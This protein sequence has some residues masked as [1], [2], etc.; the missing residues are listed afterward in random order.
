M[1]VCISDSIWLPSTL[2]LRVLSD[3]MYKAVKVMFVLFSFIS[4]GYSQHGLNLSI[5]T[6]YLKTSKPLLATAEKQWKTDNQVINQYTDLPSLLSN[7]ANTYQKSYGNGS[8]ST[9]SIR[10]GSTSHSLLMWN[11]VPLLSPMLGLQNLSLIP[12]EISDKVSLSKD[13]GSTLWGSG[14]ISGAINLSSQPQFKP[15]QKISLGVN[16]GSFGLYKNSI[17]TTLSSSK[18]EFRLRWIDRGADGDFEYVVGNDIKQLDNAAYAQENLISELF[19]KPTDTDVLSF[20]FWRQ[21]AMTEIPPTTTQNFSDA[22]Q[23]DASQKYLL[24]W[25]KVK[26]RFSLNSKV[27]YIADSQVYKDPIQSISSL[28]EFQTLFAESNLKYE[29]TSLSIFNL[30]ISAINN[31]AQSKN[32]IVEQEEIRLAVYPSYNWVRGAFS[33]HIATR[34]EWQ[35]KN[36]NPIMPSY[37]LSYSSDAILIETNVS[38]NYRNPSLNDLYWNPGGN[39][40][41]LPESGWS[42]GLA[43]KY[44]AAKSDKLDYT[45]SVDLYNRTIANWI[46]WSLRDGTSFFSPS[47][48]AKVWSRGLETEI[49]LYYTNND[50]AFRGAINYSLTKSTNQVKISSPDIAVGEQLLYTPMHMWSIS[51]KLIYKDISINLNNQYVGKT[52]GINENI[53][54]YLITN[55]F[56]GFKI[57]SEKKQTDT[58][59]FLR[60]NNLWNNNYR[61]IE[62]RPMPGRNIELGINYT[63]TN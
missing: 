34:L 50:W 26:D 25:L 61:V 3:I 2:V 22:S 42:Q 4:I 17:H 30:G 39:P 45:F 37:K 12:L 63:I 7:G 46:L 62:R 51:T 52:K 20:H 54:A 18:L 41:L 57:G 28:N 53:E 56:L 9:L 36:L 19:Y 48:I 23:E 58:D 21:S 60:C 5:D 14:A 15:L 38:R 24:K 6:I 40:S 8:L 47:N 11:D 27:A 35:G 55:L 13:G 1:Y 16:A 31:T 49:D 59:L 44:M 43:L 10:G 29:A 32:Y 33:N